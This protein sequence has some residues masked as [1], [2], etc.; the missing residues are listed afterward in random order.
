MNHVTSILLA[1]QHGDQHA[2]EE[3]LPLVYAELRR[4]AAQKLA[5]ET[6]GQTLDATALVHESYLKLIG[7]SS[8]TGWLPNMRPIQAAFGGSGRSSST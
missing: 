4:L 1:A 5:C 7:S 3:L 2:S 8:C 6:P